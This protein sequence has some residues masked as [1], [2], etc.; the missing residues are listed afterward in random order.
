MNA[1]FEMPTLRR[2]GEN[3]MC[4][5]NERWRTSLES[6]FMEV[7]HLSVVSTSSKE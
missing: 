2:T 4:G 7:H 3:P 1:A 5:K 6:D